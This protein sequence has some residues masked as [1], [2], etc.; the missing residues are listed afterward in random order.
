M[1]S[2]RERFSELSTYIVALGAPCIRKTARLAL[3][4]SWSPFSCLTFVF[5]QAGQHENRK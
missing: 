1:F 2:T 5:G 4:V 3:P